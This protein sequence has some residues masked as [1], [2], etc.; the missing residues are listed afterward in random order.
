M[1]IYYQDFS[2][3]PRRAPRGAVARGLLYAVSV[4]PL[5]FAAWVLLAQTGWMSAIIPALTAVAAGLLA[6]A[7]EVGAWLVWPTAL[8]I[9]FSA[10]A[11]NAVGNLAIIRGVEPSLAGRATGILLFGFLTGL[12]VGAPMTGAIVDAS[13]RYTLAWLAVGAAGVAA[14]MV[15]ATGPEPP[16]VGRGR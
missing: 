5:S 11:W 4:A 2:V 14:A 10:V 13:G 3:T 15:V 7:P 12:T 1:V 6:V 16:V 9:A 8:L